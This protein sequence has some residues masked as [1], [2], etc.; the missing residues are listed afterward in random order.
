MNKDEVIEMVAV[1]RSLPDVVNDLAAGGP[2]T[3]VEGQRLA[4]CVLGTGAHEVVGYTPP[5]EFFP[6]D[7]SEYPQPDGMSPA[8]IVKYTMSR[9]VD[10]PDR[11]RERIRFERG[12][13]DLHQLERFVAA[14][15]DSWG[16]ELKNFYRNPADRVRNVPQGFHAI[17]FEVC[18]PEWHCEPGTPWRPVRTPILARPAL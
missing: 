1:E 14:R 3:A 17:R 16:F 12:F 9:Y 2:L 15:G 6:G 11:D 10:Q 4:D 8:A 7:P 18:Q 13:T 5:E